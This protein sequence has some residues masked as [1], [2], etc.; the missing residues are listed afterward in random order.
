MVLGRTQPQSGT[1][2]KWMKGAAEAFLISG[3]GAEE[4]LG[5]VDMG[6]F[7]LG[8][9]VEGGLTF[10]WG[11]RGL[12]EAFKLLEGHAGKRHDGRS[13]QAKRDRA[14]P[15]RQWRHP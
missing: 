11:P 5:L 12:L 6:L 9:L 4:P 14:A 3:A 15:E 10:L 1:L 2:S 8:R 13:N 7:D